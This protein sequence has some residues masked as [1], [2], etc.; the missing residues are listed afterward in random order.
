GVPLTSLRLSVNQSGTS[1]LRDYRRSHHPGE[2]LPDTL[3]PRLH[4]LV[5]ATDQ[6]VPNTGATHVL[7]DLFPVGDVVQGGRTKWVQTDTGQPASKV[8]SPTHD[9]ADTTDATSDKTSTLRVICPAR[10]S[11]TKAIAC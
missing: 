3:T 2:C 4:T 7:R 9:V 11:L 1:S 8:D 6:P 5:G 10:N